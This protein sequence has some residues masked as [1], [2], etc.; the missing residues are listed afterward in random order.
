MEDLRVQ[1]QAAEAVARAAAQRA[2]PLQPRAAPAR[3]HA[4]G[5]RGLEQV[6]RVDLPARRHLAAAQVVG[7]GSPG[8]FGDS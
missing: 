7:D 2:Q 8:L 1:M 4:A 5:E 6:A 3:A